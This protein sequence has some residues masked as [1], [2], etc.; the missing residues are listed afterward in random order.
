VGEELIAA[1]E[2]GNDFLEGVYIDEGLAGDAQE[3][4][5]REFLFQFF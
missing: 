5:R 4:G 1:G 3:R 2:P